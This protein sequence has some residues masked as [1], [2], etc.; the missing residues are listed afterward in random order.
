MSRLSQF[1][2]FLNIENIP[3][4][5]KEWFFIYDSITRTDD[6]KELR[7]RYHQSLNSPQITNNSQTLLD[8]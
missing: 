8:L 6:I 4:N 2:H 5:D 1:I 3:Q 7:I